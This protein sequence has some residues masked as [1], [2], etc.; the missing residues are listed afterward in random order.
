M[1]QQCHK[2]VYSND[3]F[4]QSVVIRVTRGTASLC[5]AFG[6]ADRQ[7]FPGRCDGSAGVSSGPERLLQ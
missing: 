7:V 2:A 4:G 3:R 1:I 6:V 5:Q